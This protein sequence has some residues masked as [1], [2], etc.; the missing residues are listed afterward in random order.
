MKRLSEFKDLDG[1]RLISKLM[2]P[3]GRIVQNKE[4]ASA[5]AA[6][7]AEGRDLSM[8]ELA[9]VMLE[10]G[11]QDIMSMLALLNEEDPADYH[12][13]AATVMADVLTMFGDPDMQALFG[14]QRQTTPSSGSAS[15]STEGQKTPDASSDTAEPVSSGKQ[16]KKSGKDTSPTP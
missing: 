5:R 11:A 15:E 7:K 9:G 6:A 10:S 14:L 3:I 12:C 16:K 13:N 4:V 1:I 8:L 2:L